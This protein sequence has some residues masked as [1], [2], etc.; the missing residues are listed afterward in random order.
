[1]EKYIRNVKLTYFV[2]VFSFKSMLSSILQEI[3]Q[4]D[5]KYWNKQEHWQTI[6]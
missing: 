4:N 1:M 5:G 6:S 2:P 3:P